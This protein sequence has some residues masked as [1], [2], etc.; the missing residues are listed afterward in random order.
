MLE[1]VI[2]DDHG[3]SLTQPSPGSSTLV[4][5]FDAARFKQQIALI[6][7]QQLLRTER[8]RPRGIS[9]PFPFFLTDPTS[10][11]PEDQ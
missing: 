10:E 5:A 1:A 8:T 6:V 4:T 2:G 9:R 3:M 7:E 11:P